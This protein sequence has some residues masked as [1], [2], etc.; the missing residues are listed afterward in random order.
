MRCCW[1]A[2]AADAG[3]FSQSFSGGRGRVPRPAKH[4][5]SHLLA[6]LLHEVGRRGLLRMGAK[7]QGHRLQAPASCTPWRKATFFSR[8]ASWPFDNSRAAS[9]CTLA[10]YRPL[11][12]PITVTTCG[13]GDKA[14]VRLTEEREAHQVG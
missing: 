8:G 9:R 4:R 7:Q 11:Q 13:G 14:T 3:G 6:H 2:G 12:L 5:A 10:G 1:G